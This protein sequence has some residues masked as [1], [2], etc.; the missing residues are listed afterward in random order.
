MVEILIT[1]LD[2]FCLPVP[3][4]RLAMKYSKF[5]YLQFY[6]N[7]HELTFIVE[8]VYFINTFDITNYIIH[9]GLSTRE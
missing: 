2:K 5:K 9:T 3:D 1:G 6:A 4:V 8:H 7:I